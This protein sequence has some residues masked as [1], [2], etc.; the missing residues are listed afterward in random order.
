M[1]FIE[2]RLVEDYILEKLTEKG[3]KNV[4]AGDLE[5]DSLEEPLL[6]PNLIRAIQKN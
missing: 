1:T 3:W 2:K 5:R 4:P 6:I